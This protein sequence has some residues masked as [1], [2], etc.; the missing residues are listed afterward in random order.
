MIRTL[1]IED[2][3]ADAEA[4]QAA[5]KKYKEVAFTA[6]T[7]SAVKARQLVTEQ[8]FDA[9]IV[10]LEL[11]DGDGVSF[12]M[13]LP[14]LLPH[15][16]PFILVTTQS[17]S[18][19]VLRC[20][21][22]QGAYIIQKF[23]SNYTPDCILG[24]VT[25]ITPYTSDFPSGP[26]PYVSVCSPD[27]MRKKAVLE[28]MRSLLKS[29][30]GSPSLSG[31]T[32]IVDATVMFME[33]KQGTPSLSKDIYPAISERYSLDHSRLS[34]QS[35]EHNMRYFIETMWKNNASEM[36]DEKVPCDKETGKCTI[37]EFC[38]YLRDRYKNEYMG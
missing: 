5:T 35:I 33:C 18:D 13:D 26:A 34:Y 38:C 32:Y 8:D 20:V 6:V 30:G 15:S 28:K 24:L 27:E 37:R 11:P 23:N 36:L 17:R 22:D 12:I 29:F 9:M 10:D 4:L 21:R 25:R 19:P 1:L 3:P 7:D 2:N 31:F 14:M 16:K